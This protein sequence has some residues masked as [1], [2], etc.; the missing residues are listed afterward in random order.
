M[1]TPGLHISPCDAPVSK[2]E[3][4]V[5][6]K[7]L[8]L[9]AKKLGGKRNALLYDITIHIHLYNGDHMRVTKKQICVDGRVRMLSTIVLNYK[10][11]LVR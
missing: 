8:T 3:I 5:A 9:Q 2:V 1:T 6:E 11:Q 4:K 7:I 10:Y